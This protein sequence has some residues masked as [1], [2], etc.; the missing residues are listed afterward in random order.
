LVWFKNSV[1]L[2]A[3]TRYE[4]DYNYNTCIAVLK[5]TNALKSDIGEYLVNA[6]NPVG[7]D[8]TKCILFVDILPNV[9]ETPLINP[10][11]FKFL[12]A[13]P[14]KA[15]INDN[16]DEEEKQRY[17]PPRVIVPL[18]DTQI[19]EGQNIQ[20]ACTIV[21]YPKPKVPSFILALQN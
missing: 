16:D 13:P 8:S 1:V 2:P 12:D 10:E 17:F 6:H 11:A 3:S 9:D 7:Q 21:G 18:P 4:T 15:P 20:L 19:K 14:I 5:I